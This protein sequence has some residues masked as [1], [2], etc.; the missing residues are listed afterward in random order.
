PAPLVAAA[1]DFVLE[2]LYA[3]KKISR[4]D[5]FQYQGAEPQRRGPRGTAPETLVDRELPLRGEK[6]KYYN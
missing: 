6:K 5:E 4:S 2:G 3:Q 1:V